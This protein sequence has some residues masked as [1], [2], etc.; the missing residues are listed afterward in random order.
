MDFLKEATKILCEGTND[1]FYD[2]HLILEDA[3]SPVTKKTIENLY[4]SVID[5]GHIDFDDI[6]KSKG[7]ISNYSGYKTMIQVLANLK[8]L[9]KNDLSYQDITRYVN[10][11]QKAIE[12]L[13]ANS[14]LYAQA[15]AK[16]NEVIML[17]YNTFVFTCVEATTSLLYQFADFM[18]TPSAHELKVS[19]KNTK[20]RADAFYVEQLD[21]FNRICASGN[22]K[23]YLNTVISSG[24][25]NFFG[26]DDAL[27]VGSLAV[28]STV[29]LSI[30][31][32][33]RKLIYTFQDMRNRIADDLELQAYYLELNKAAVEANQAKTADQKKK[34]LDKQ[35]KVRL[36]FLRKAEKLRV[37]SVHAEQL[38]SKSISDDNRTMSVDS[39]HD[40]V[41]NGDF[42]IV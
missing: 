38:A 9:A 21:S 26:V 35:E 39:M 10:I 37:K 14:V 20:Y 7:N 8:D 34:I 22:Y 40:Q 16:K 29:M 32:V 3:E 19:L 15:F 24:K 23:K 41:D 5:K 42:S 31:P 27:L 2:V 33:T 11:V 30:V 4:Q 6:P 25:E 28:V 18:K 1:S 17:E 13:Q 12:N 36:K